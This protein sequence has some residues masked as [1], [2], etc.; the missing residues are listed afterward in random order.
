LA[1]SKRQKARGKAIHPDLACK[2]LPILKNKL[3]EA[4]IMNRLILSFLE[5]KNCLISIK[6][7]L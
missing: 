3:E 2:Q 1:K 4:Q 5:I 6:K 7:E